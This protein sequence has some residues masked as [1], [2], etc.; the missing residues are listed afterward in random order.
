[1]YCSVK[2]TQHVTATN[3]HAFLGFFLSESYI[4][5][6]V[7]SFLN[8]T[9]S[10]WFPPF[11]ILHF[12]SGF[13]LSESYILFL[14]FF[15]VESYILVVSSF[16]NPTLFFLVFSLL[17]PTFPFWFLHFWILHSLSGF[18][19]SESYIFFVVS[20]FLN[21][22]F[23]LWFLHFWI[24]QFPFWF[25]PFI[26][27][28]SLSC[29]FISESYILFLVSSFLNPTFSFLFLPFWI[30]PPSIKHTNRVENEKL[31]LNIYGNIVWWPRYCTFY[32]LSN[33]L[34]NSNTINNT[35]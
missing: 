23:S 4:F 30:P 8:P 28:H 16:L 25:L 29:F 11:W 12:L 15:P 27:L 14:G 18:F 5:F 22:T 19:P 24:L 13:L 3:V 31:L 20:S 35:Q 10:F 1:M 2:S 6:L 32:F 33:P 26:I 34:E 7:S 9:F 17:N 21:P